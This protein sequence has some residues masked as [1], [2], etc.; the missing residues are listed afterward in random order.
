[1]AGIHRSRTLNDDARQ[2][3]I[4]LGMAGIHRSR[5]LIPRAPE[6]IHKLGMAGIHRSRTLAFPQKIDSGRLGM[7]GIHRSRTLGPVA[8]PL[9][10]GWGWPGFTAHVHY[11]R[12][13]QV[14]IVAG[15]GR[16]SP[17]TYT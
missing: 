1:M 6:S 13:R 14:R 12:V 17:L 9:L 15:D 3:M 5:T 11:L 8:L 2:V 4:K 7:A 10:F 16:D